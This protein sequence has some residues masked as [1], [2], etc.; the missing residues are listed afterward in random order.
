M[1][2]FKFA[3]RQLLKNPG[4][5][6]VAVLTLALGIGANTAMFNCANALFRAFQYPGMALRPLDFGLVALRYKQ[7]DSRNLSSVHQVPMNADPD[8]KQFGSSFRRDGEVLGMLNRQRFAI[9]EMQL[10]GAER[11]SITH[12]LKVRHFHIRESMDNGFSEI[13]N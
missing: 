9:G 5:T 3:F 1:N 12:F 8:H 11:S 2:D 4:F 6:T 13:F 7:T 10:E